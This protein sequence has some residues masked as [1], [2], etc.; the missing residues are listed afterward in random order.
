MGQLVAV[1]H[2][3]LDGVMQAPGRPD[4]DTRNGFDLGGW[5]DGP[6]SRDPEAIG[7]AMA[8]GATSSSMLFG[9]RTYND[10]VGHWLGTAEPNPFT[11]IIRETTKYVCS[12]SPETVLAHPNSILM[13]GPAER[14]VAD[15]KAAE[16]GQIVLLG[17]GD[18]VRSLLAAGLVDQLV[19]T[20]VPVVLGKGTRLL[21][22]VPLNLNPVETWASST[23]LI[24]ARYDITNHHD[25]GT[26][27]AS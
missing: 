8:G 27:G 23:G 1:E 4:E 2:V 25:Q 22:E 6:L 11:E 14:T 17:S 21:G 16:D 13:A 20:I 26:D 10:L 24:V 5:A 18:L 15:L 12:Q 3:S 7:R 9:R 19:L